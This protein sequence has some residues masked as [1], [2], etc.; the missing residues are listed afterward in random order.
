METGFPT[1]LRSKVFNGDPF[2]N[3]STEDTPWKEYMPYSEGDVNF[4]FDPKTG[5][6]IIWSR[7]REGAQEDADFEPLLSSFLYCSVLSHK[8]FEMALAFVLA[9]K[10]ASNTLLATHLIEIFERVLMENKHIRISARADVLAAK[11]RDPA[12]LTY[13]QPLLFYKGYQAIQA[14]RISNALWRNGQKVLALALQT[15]MSE[16]FSIDIHPAATIG[17]GILLDHGTGV[18]I[19]ETAV[20]GD[21]VSILHGVTLGGTGKHD[22]D[23]HPKVGEGVLIGANSTVLGNIKVGKGSMVAAGSLVLKPVRPYTMVAGSPAKE[24]GRTD[25]GGTIGL[26]A[27]TMKQQVVR[28]FC[29]DWEAA[30]GLAMEKE[31]ATQPPA[32]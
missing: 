31:A 17:M 10:L 18:V 21:R 3:P 16:V 26:P 1:Y 22:K 13:A 6:D 24:V 25:I 30:V 15:R 5:E 27:I 7:I 2:C 14:H 4:L 23:R 28:T 19:G 11:C 8:S 20:I 29:E 12:C 9:Q 32:P